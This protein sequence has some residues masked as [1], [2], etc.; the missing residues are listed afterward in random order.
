MRGRQ[1]RGDFVHRYVR[2]TYELRNA[3]EPERIK[4]FGDNNASIPPIKNKFMSFKAV[5]SVHINLFLILI[6]VT[7]YCGA[8]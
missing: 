5:L 7:E 3:F 2:I 6:L 4:D 8:V 1:A